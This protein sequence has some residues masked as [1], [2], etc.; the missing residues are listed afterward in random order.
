MKHDKTWDFDGWADVYDADV[1]SDCP[2]HAR[3][4]E[5]LDAVV[6]AADV[7]VGK[8][9]LDIGTGTGNLALPCLKLGATVV[10][11]DPSD[12]MLAK[13]RE[14]TADYPAVEFRLVADPFLNIPYPDVFFDAVV[15][16]Y[17]FH[18]VPHRS[19]PDA[20]REMVRV[21]RPGAMWALGDLAFQNQEAA[22]EALGLYR[23]WLEEEYFAL[24]D[25]LVPVFRE[26]GMKLD[27]TRFSPVT[28]VLWAKKPV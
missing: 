9:V 18:H 27:A 17:A 8:I 26:L 13:A 25:E 19:K 12:R 28:W 7:T 4:D 24:I 16:T 21:L 1:R 5:V 15:S 22:R 6:Q 20:V 2:L 14:K 23:D 11:L 3:Y 10:G